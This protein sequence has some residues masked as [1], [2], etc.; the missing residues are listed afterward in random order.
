MINIGYLNYTVRFCTLIESFQIET[1]EDITLKVIE[2]AVIGIVLVLVI[3]LSTKFLR[4]K[5]TTELREEINMIKYGDLYQNILLT[6]R[7]KLNKFMF[8]ISQVM[9]LAVVMIPLL[10][11][12]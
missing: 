1:E 5:N 11:K 2:A 12:D 6:D 7:S 4:Q 9:K 8:P 10:F 3:L